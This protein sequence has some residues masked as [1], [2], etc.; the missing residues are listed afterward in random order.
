MKV[1]FF[2]QPQTD[3]ENNSHPPWAFQSFVNSCNGPS[4]LHLSEPLPLLH[5][6][7][8]MCVRAYILTG[9]IV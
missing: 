3:T 6:L 5:T 2:S 7:W 1:S 4:A 8:R 9:R